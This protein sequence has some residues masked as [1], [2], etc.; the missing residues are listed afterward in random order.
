MWTLRISPYINIDDWY[1]WCGWAVIFQVN[2]FDHN[3][4]FVIKLVLVYFEKKGQ[5]VKTV[6]QFCGPI[7]P[8]LHMLIDLIGV[9]I[10]KVDGPIDS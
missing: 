7:Q 2:H 9:A 3:R 1:I 8:H 10:K 5:I 4:I 6:E